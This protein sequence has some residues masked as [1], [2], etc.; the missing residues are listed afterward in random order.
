MADADH[1][2]PTGGARRAWPATAARWT[3][4]LLARLDVRSTLV[5]L[6]ILGGVALLAVEAPVGAATYGLPLLVAFLLAVL[7]TGCLPLASVRPATAGI[8]SI[9]VVTVLQALTTGS[10][11]RPW[12]WW[13]VLLITEVAI[14]FVITLLGPWRVAV[15]CWIGSVVTSMVVAGL[16]GATDADSINLI[17]YASI[18]AAFL[19][20][21]VVLA[22]WHRIRALLLR[23]RQVSA[24]EYSR[25]VLAEERT[26]I[27]RELHDVV[28]HSMSI[29]NVQ[30]ATARY[31]HPD[32]DAR[33]LAEFE[34]IGAASR[35][36]LDEMRGLLDV[37]RQG[38][39]PG[40]KRPQ[41][42]FEDLPDL[43]AQAERAGMAVTFVASAPPGGAPI[44]DVVGLVAYRIVQEALSNAIRHALG[45]AV[46]VRST[47]G[48]DVLELAIRN[49]PGTASGSD[50]DA[51]YGL[52]G[53]A[54]R[55]ASVGG[56]VLCGATEDGGFEVTAAL[57]LRRHSPRT[58][59]A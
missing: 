54:E 2:V 8:L 35:Q 59:H 40:E 51:G 33:A 20:V 19:V 11:A 17:V 25:R 45:S 18:S 27:A 53:M 29:I 22:Q 41:P 4:A 10:A 16:R 24:E 48:A 42:Q 52:I 55:A 32:F 21:A 57:P 28:A 14:L 5:T 37:L 43:V 49:G 3:L 7:H 56:T 36:A 15:A 12:P 50:G 47:R 31:R 23:E 58:E 38:D 46:E 26:R 13:V 9:A 1:A 44:G 34:D 30:A 6:V 39:G